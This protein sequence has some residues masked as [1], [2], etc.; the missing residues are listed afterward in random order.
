MQLTAESTDLGGAARC[1]LKVVKASNASMSVAECASKVRRMTAAQVCLARLLGER[2]M[3]ED[4][5]EEEEEEGEDAL[6]GSV[7]MTKSLGGNWCGECSKFTNRL[8]S[9]WEFPGCIQHQACL[10][11]V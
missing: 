7:D 4:N 10:T 9:T 1:I 5:A 8:D 11:H 2:V 6:A 3:A